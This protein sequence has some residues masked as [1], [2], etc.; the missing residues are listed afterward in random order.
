M[1]FSFRC[2]GAA[3]DSCAD[4]CRPVVHELVGECVACFETGHCASLLVVLRRHV[5]S[6]VCRPGTC[7]E[8]EAL[9]RVTESMTMLL[10]VRPADR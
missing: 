2:I 1:L 5:W 10:Q 7:L 4:T 6:L 3:V 8:T 9:S